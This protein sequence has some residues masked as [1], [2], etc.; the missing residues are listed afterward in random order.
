[1]KENPAP[2]AYL[3][4]QQNSSTDLRPKGPSFGISHKY[5][6]KV[7]LPKEKKNNLNNQSTYSLRNRAK[8]DK[9]FEVMLFN[10]YF[11]KFLFNLIIKFIL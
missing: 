2:G 1:M 8:A 4:G 10:E 9:G 11:H 6:E 3:L 7:M 5:Y